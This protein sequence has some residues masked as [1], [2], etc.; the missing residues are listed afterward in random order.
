M[1]KDYIEISTYFFMEDINRKETKEVGTICFEV[2]IPM[3]KTKI[4]MEFFHVNFQK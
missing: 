3:K 4:F 1:K 2:R